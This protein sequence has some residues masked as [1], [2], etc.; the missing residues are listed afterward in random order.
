[1]SAKQYQIDAMTRHQVFLMRYAKGESNK[2]IKTLNRLRRDIQARLLQEPTEFQRN[3]LSVVLADIEQL[4]RQLSQDVTK[5]LELM[6]NEFAPTEAAFIKKINDKVT[7]AD[8]ALPTD[9]ALVASVNLAP[10]KI[11]PNARAITINE[12]IKQFSNKKTKQTIQLITDGVTLGDTTKQIAD[13]VAG[14][15]NT[16]Q[17]RQLDAVVHTAVMHTSSI[18]RNETYK[19]NDEVIDGWEWVATL[20]NKTSLVCAGN[21]GKVFPLNV[22]LLPAHYNCRSADIPHIKDEY[23]IPGF[24]GDRPAI[25]A[26]GVEH[27]GA[28]KTY[29]GWLKTQPK[30]FIDEALGVERSKLFR[31]GKIKIDQFT[32]PTG[33]TYSLMELDRM[34]GLT[35]IE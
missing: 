16:I 3:R 34:Y 29:G 6:V 33:R 26:D 22:V 1:M 32:D 19:H 2:A 13:K 7:V 24:D 18:A 12:A 28:N 10:M 35:A 5:Q 20:D 15:T 30:E 23:K 14:L 11:S 9:A 31:S 27:V 17:R 25:G 21:D 4:W 8:F